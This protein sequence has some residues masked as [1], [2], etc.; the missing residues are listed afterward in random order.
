MHTRAHTQMLSS[1]CTNK[2][3]LRQTT[4]TPFFSLPFFPPP[5]SPISHSFHFKASY[6]RRSLLS[7]HFHHHP[8][9]N[10]HSTCQTFPPACSPLGSKDIIAYT[11]LK[12]SSSTT[13]A[14]CLALSGT[15][16]MS[17]C[18]FVSLSMHHVFH[19]PRLPAAGPNKSREN[20]ESSR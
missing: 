12:S 6:L 3:L 11:A 13:H 7:C 9:Q 18:G 16:L 15:W 1:I 5:L 8:P 14:P 10:G 20:P 2:L 4:H 17:L 19:C